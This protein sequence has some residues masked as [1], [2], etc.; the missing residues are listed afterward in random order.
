MYL[1]LCVQDSV[2]DVSVSYCFRLSKLVSVLWRE[3]GYTMK[4]SLS[5]RD[6][7]R[8]Y[9]IFH[10]ISWLDIIK[11]KSSIDLAGRSILKEL[12][13]CIPSTAGPYGKI[14]SSILSNTGDLKFNIIMLSIWEWNIMWKVLHWQLCIYIKC[15]IDT[16]LDSN[17]KKILKLFWNMSFIIYTVDVDT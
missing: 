13:F 14:L 15:T 10:R 7:P 2:F 11:Y 1:L 9:A 3:D 6:F 17:L 12:I 8:V 16:Q 4:Y 5:P